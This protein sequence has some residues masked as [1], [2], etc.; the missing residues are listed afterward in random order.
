MEIFDQRLC[1]LGEGPLWHP[2]RQALYWCDIESDLILGPEGFELACDQR[3]SALGWVDED[4][5]F[6]TTDQALRVLDLSDQ[7]WTTLMD[8]EDEIAETRTNDGRADPWGGF[9]VSTM[10]RDM[11]APVGRIYRF[12]QGELAVVVEGL[13]CPN[14]I[15]FDQSR[16]RAFFADSM[17][18]E[19]RTL[20]LDPE[21][22]WPTGEDYEVFAVVEGRDAPD[23]AI[24]DAAGNLWNAEWGPGRLTCYDPEGAILSRHALPARQ[25]TCPA[26]DP[27]TGDLY[28]TS[29]RVG[30]RD[31]GPAD[32]ATFRLAGAVPAGAFLPEPR[33]LL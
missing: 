20:N 18:S 9:W 12:F 14:A 2:L 5:L 23:G 33:V 30:L 16:N 21:T 32:G 13:S 11:S 8:L 31:G 24:T 7:S 29:A 15:C 10:L 17:R 6:V 25:L 3:P 26:A 27:V 28:L 1:E 4:R 22:G 19:I